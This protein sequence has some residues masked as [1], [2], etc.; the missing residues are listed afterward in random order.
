[1]MSNVWL[2]AVHQLIIPK[3]AQRIEAMAVTGESNMA[4]TKSA[5][6][7]AAEARF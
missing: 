6:H 5:A 2:S 7:P 4:R 1:M 3:G